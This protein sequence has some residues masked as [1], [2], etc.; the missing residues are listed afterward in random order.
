MKLQ[1]VIEQYIVHKRSLGIQFKATARVLRAFCKAIG[2]VELDEIARE[3]VK[4]F[5]YG[6]GPVTNSIPPKRA[7]LSGFYRYL[8]NRGY[9]SESRVPR[10]FPKRPQSF[11]PHI[12]TMD[13][14]RRILQ[15]TSSQIDRCKI[16]AHTMRF[17]ILLLY[18]AALRVSEAISLT[19]RDIDLNQNVLTI[20]D[21]KF[22]KTRWVPIS[23]DLRKAFDAY[24][25]IRAELNHPT[26]PEAFLLLT[27]DSQPIRLNRASESFKRLC[28]VAKVC[29]KDKGRYGPR[30]HD[31]RHSFA[32][33]RL[34]ACYRE[35]GDVG[36][37][38][39]Q[40][41]TYLGHVQPASTQY[42]LTLTPELLRHVSALFENYAIPEIHHD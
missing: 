25:K 29:R 40:L 12:Y 23:P 28:Q 22:F 17:L 31:L 26:P 3:R 27:R 20:R 5:I 42:Y 8:I 13:E 2:N 30:L 38:L 34:L 35:G 41:S 1:D 10:E 36:M 18:G 24:L 9:V 4:S 15:A 32:V 21:T 16:E 19:I 6:S 39:V 11:I 33:H 37:F 7:A 14:L